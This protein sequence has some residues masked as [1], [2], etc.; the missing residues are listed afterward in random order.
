MVTGARKVLV[1]VQGKVEAGEDVDG[2]KWP[3]LQNYEGRG[4]SLFAGWSS[5][6]VFR[7]WA[8]I[9]RSNNSTIQRLV[10]G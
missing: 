7:R 5:Q 10:R 8:V 6:L 9:Q 1:V 4:N 2:A 3:K